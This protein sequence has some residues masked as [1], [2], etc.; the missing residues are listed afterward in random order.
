MA[1]AA[2]ARPYRRPQ[3]GRPGLGLRD[4]SALMDA[5]IWRQM[6]KAKPFS[7][8]LTQTEGGFEQAGA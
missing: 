3:F 1:R 5:A 8:P 4:P 2:S 7:W 6:D